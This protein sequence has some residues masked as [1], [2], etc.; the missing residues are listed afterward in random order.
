[1]KARTSFSKLDPL[2]WRQKYQ[3]TCPTNRTWQKDILLLHPWQELPVSD[4]W[5]WTLLSNTAHLIEI[6]TSFEVFQRNICSKPNHHSIHSVQILW[7]LLLLRTW[8]TYQNWWPILVKQWMLGVAWFQPS[9]STW[10]EFFSP[11]DSKMICRIMWAYGI[12]SSCKADWVNTDI[13]KHGLIQSYRRN[14]ASYKKLS[15]ILILQ[16]VT[17]Q[18]CDKQKSIIY[19]IIYI[20]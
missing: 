14:S 2:K 19:N 3:P 9:K 16:I 11:L 10:G 8:R 18:S 13:D 5:E 4:W 20:S 12:K 17:L 7:F 1:M 6:N 15:L